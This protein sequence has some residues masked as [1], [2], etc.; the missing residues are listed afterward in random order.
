MCGRAD[1]RQ[2]I[3]S[4]HILQPAYFGWRHEQIIST[5]NKDS[6]FREE[7]SDQWER[8]SVVSRCGFDVERGR[9][10]AISKYFYIA[11]PRNDW[12]VEPSIANMSLHLHM[13]CTH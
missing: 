1:K 13:K 8:F 5:S 6:T 9:F 7:V 10:R 12:K 4:S 11:F 2:T 3:R